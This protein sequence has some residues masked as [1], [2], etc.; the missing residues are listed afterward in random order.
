MPSTSTSWYCSP[1][2]TSATGT[3]SRTA[4]AR[5]DG[6]RASAD[7]D[8]TWTSGSSRRP[9][10]SSV[11][12]GS[13]LLRSGSSAASTWEGVSRCV[14]D[15][16]M[17]RTARAGEKTAAARSPATTATSVAA[18][19]RMF[20]FRRFPLGSGK[21]RTFPALSDPC[22]VPPGFS[23]AG[24]PFLGPSFFGPSFFNPSFVSPAKVALRAFRAGCGAGSGTDREA[25]ITSWLPPASGLAVRAGRRGSPGAALWTCRWGG[26]N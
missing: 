10:S 5:P 6:G 18:N 19:T 8:F 7:T 20:L 13:G 21:A 11:I 16:E 24:P 26:G 17:V 25:E 9:T 12:C 22:A 2:L 3:R 4:T 14:P 23:L 1:C 15:T